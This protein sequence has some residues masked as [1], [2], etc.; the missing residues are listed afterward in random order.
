VARNK[1]DQGEATTV[2]TAAGP[3]APA[4][5]AVE[6][7]TATRKSRR[8][9]SDAEANRERLLAAAAAAIA[10]EGRSVPLATIAAEAGVGIGTL[11]RSYA[12]RE[13]VLHALQLRAYGFLNRI[14]DDVD[15]RRLSGLDSVGAFLT[16]TLAISE[17]LVLPLHGAPPLVSPEAVQARQAINQRLERFM[18]R[19]RAEYGIRA[20]ANATDII[21]FSAL[22][23]QPLPHGPAW[24]H[25]AARQIALFLNGLAANGPI[26]V[27]GPPVEPRDVE[28]AF[29]LAAAARSSNRTSDT[30]D[31][32]V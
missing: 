12:D 1:P 17:Q 16:G 27:P 32:H 22:I 14:L 26:G 3:D 18:E 24:Q 31:S 8:P 10:R 6:E 4:N 21:V 30:G 19:G 2:I 7:S 23:T 5:P 29:T 9:R 28:R 13:A 20:P 15:D 25:M 11:Y